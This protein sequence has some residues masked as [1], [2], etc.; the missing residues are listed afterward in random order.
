MKEENA[1]LKLALEEKEIEIKKLF[2]NQL[3]KEEIEAMK[4][5]KERDSS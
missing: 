5:S 2:K 3:T 4:E 1:H